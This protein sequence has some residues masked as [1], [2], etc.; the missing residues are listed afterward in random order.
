MRLPIS[1]SSPSRNTTARNPSHFGSYSWPGGI[2]R[3][4][5]A[6][7]GFTGGMTGRSTQGKVRSGT[8]GTDGLDV[9]EVTMGKVVSQAAMSLDGFIAQQDNGIGA[10]FAFYDNGP[11]EIPTAMPHLTFHVTPPTADYLRSVMAGLGALVVGRTL[12]DVTDGWDGRHPFDVPV[13]VVTH[14]PPQDWGHD[15]APFTFVTDGVA[16]AVEAAQRVAG[17]RVVGV[18]AGTIATQCLHL[19]LLDEVCVDLVPVV[20]GEGRRYF[21]DSDAGAV[22]LGDPTTSIAGDRVTHLVFPV[23]KG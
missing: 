21:E 11:I 13:F 20:M 2:S 6:S 22:L 9:N 19:G 17:D 18:T 8:D 4:S 1:T 5:L 3:A 15:D 7:I 10:L 16:A 14:E 23:T 12:F